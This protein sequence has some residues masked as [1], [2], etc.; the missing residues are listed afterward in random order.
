MKTC[1]TK[2]CDKPRC[3]NT[4]G[5]QQFK[6]EEHQKAQWRS[7]HK[8]SGKRPGRPKKSDYQIPPMRPAPESLLKKIVID[9]GSGTL[10]ITQVVKIKELGCGNDPAKFDLLMQ[11]YK[12]AGYQV[13]KRTGGKPIIS[14]VKPKV[15]VG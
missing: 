3:Y 2:G 7:Y 10:V 9:E 1:T 5:V 14:L 12:D 4:K 6:C 8:S 11:F 15:G 13:E